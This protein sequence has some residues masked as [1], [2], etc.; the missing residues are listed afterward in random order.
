M[1]NCEE[2]LRSIIHEEMNITHHIE[3]GN[4]ER[5]SKSLPRPLVAQFLY[6]N[7]LAQVKR[8]DKYLRGKPFGVNE[9]FPIEIKQ[10]RKHSFIQS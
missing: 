2:K 5:F 7:D 3:F 6:Y 10:K 9:Q 8:A 4:V 1:I